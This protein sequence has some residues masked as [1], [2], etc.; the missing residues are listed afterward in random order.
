M[1]RFSVILFTLL[2]FDW[3]AAAPAHAQFEVSGCTIW[4]H[5][6]GSVEGVEGAGN[7]WKL[8]G[9]P[10]RPVVIDCDTTQLVAD[11]MEIFNDEHRVSARG[12]V[13]YVS[14][15]N[16]IAADR[17]EFNTKTKTGTFYEASGTAHLGDR[18]D[19]SMFGTQE[20]YAYFYGAEIHKLGPKKFRITRGGF[21]T[22]V[23]P[24]PRWEITSGSVTI[25]LEDHAILRNSIFKV[26]GVPVM[27]LPAFYYPIQEDDRATGF[28]MPIYGNSTYRGQ[29]LTNQF[30]W[31][32][33]R[34]HDATLTHDW[35]TK[36]GQGYGGEYRY[37]ASGASNGNATV[38]FLNEQGVTDDGGS[39]QSPASRS[40]N[41]RSQVTQALPAGTRL[42]ANVDYFSSVVTQQLYQQDLYQA[43]NARRSWGAAT[44]SSWSGF[45]LSSA[46]NRSEL[47]TEATSSYVEGARPRVSVTRTA[48]RLGA[49][50]VYVSGSFELLASQREFRLQT[51]DGTTVSDR[52][53]TRINNVGSVRVPFPT[54]S[55][56]TVS[57]TMSWTGTRY[58]K[59][60]DP[61][62][63]AVLPEPV[64]R[65]YL[66]VGTEL[67]GPSFVRIWNRPTSQYAARI[68]H[69]IEPRFEFNRMTRIDNVARIV[70]NESSDYRIGGSTD[71]TY[72]VTNRLLLKPGGE[73]A[74][75]RNLLTVSVN[76]TYY[77]DPRTSQIDPSYSTSFLGRPPSAFSPVSILTTLTPAAGSRVNARIEYDPIIS[78][79]Q[80]L[81]LGGEAS[82]ANVF[83]RGSFS[84]R[85]LAPN[86][87]PGTSNNLLSAGTELRT[88]R[89]MLGGSF[90]I[91]YDFGRGTLVQQR[92]QGYYNAQCCGIIL[93]FQQFNYGTFVNP[94]LVPQDRRFNISFSL[95]GIGTFSNFLGALAG[96]P[97]RR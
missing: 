75:S 60:L 52:G 9:S 34:S 25:V 12:H 67:I 18:V 11:E 57:S 14:A 62:T 55:F 39:A 22:C 3:I 2:G 33:G 27:Y 23:Q 17:L 35:F 64:F 41:I 10:A 91:D 61:V 78:A 84:N 65:K 38:Y 24:T 28:L 21:T 44:T 71:I 7:R 96:Q 58:S 86:A 54:F 72:G 83:V 46:V 97:T 50:P 19:R 79:L 37:V 95:G 51:E 73:N 56:M 85:R 93:E 76:Q 29:T 6:S 66:T 26:K 90:S 30:F 88:T 81:S 45:T 16:R 68:K 40:Y 77:T 8:T 49:A 5:E 36:T 74:V 43:T 53:L 59:S 1:L 63:R 47:F 82:T 15:S 80:S 69:L 70:K 89:N 13:V 31:A 32:L 42:T 87:R 20:P 48:T 94:L 4:K 92:I